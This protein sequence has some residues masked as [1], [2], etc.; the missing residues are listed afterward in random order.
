MN[1]QITRVVHCK[2]DVKNNLEPEKRTALQRAVHT[3]SVKFKLVL[4]GFSLIRYFHLLR[5]FLKLF[6]V[7]ILNLPT[8]SFCKR[9]GVDV[10]DFSVTD[11]IWEQVEPC[12]GYKFS[13]SPIVCYNCF[14]DIWHKLGHNNIWELKRM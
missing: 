6:K 12:I 5:I 1:P 10:R 14:S 8:N 9:C 7:R 3:L 11:D 2:R 4:C 13:C